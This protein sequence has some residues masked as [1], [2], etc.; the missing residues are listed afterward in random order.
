MVENMGD[1][2]IANDR[3]FMEDAVRAAR[4]CQPEDGRN[5]PLVGAVVVR[6]GVILT[7]SHRGAREPGAHAEYTALELELPN[8]QLAGATVYTTLEPCT[9]RN[10]PKV[11]CV[12]R[13]IQRRVARVVIGMLDPNPN[14]L[15][16]GITRLRAAGIA[17]ELFPHDLM[18]QLEELNRRFVAQH[19]H[20]LAPPLTDELVGELCRRSMDDWYEA[21]N[22]VYW[23]RNFHRDANAIFTHLVEVIGSLSVLVSKKNIRKGASVEA[24]LGK[25]I[26]WWLALCGKVGVRS[27]EEML[28][29]KFPMACPY[30]RKERHEPD[31]CSERKRTNAGP[32]WGELEEIGNRNSRTR[33]KTIGD[34]QRM[35]ASIY[36]PTTTEEFSKIFA[37]L[38]EE[39]GELAEAIRVF[40]AE[41]GYFLSE[42]ADVFAWL[43][44]LNN[45]VECDLPRNERGN[46]L[47]LT[48]ARA[49]PGRC[50]D[51][52]AAV[53]TCPP[54]LASTIGRIAH[55]VPAERSS[56]REGG[57]FMTAE[58]ASRRFGGPRGA[59]PK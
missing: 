54:I 32:S 4:K 11:P 29:G 37:K 51:C 57:S 45:L 26:A 20:A 2:S 15:G 49:Y 3:A 28:W 25:S 30:C 10:H 33:P 55:E 38:T 12:E 18:A 16:R 47:E 48:V 21:L 50:L 6:D 35:F 7:T 8:E 40:P 1:N 43:M 58:A 24:Y 14:I 19:A 56:Y 9:S 39:M 31:E 27:V 53:C 22:R 52:S 36:P 42:A 5:H 17:V 46:L 23:N 13:L 59:M 41:P 34:W 44:K